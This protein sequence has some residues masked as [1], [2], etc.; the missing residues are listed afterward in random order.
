MMQRHSVRQTQIWKTEF[1]QYLD[2]FKWRKLLVSLSVSV[3]VCV[4]VCVC[5]ITETC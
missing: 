4:C 1:L 5:M 2:V 3:S